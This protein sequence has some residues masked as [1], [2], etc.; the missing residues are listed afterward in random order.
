M[1]QAEYEL[2]FLAIKKVIGWVQLVKYFAVVAAGLFVCLY[3]CQIQELL[4]SQRKR[5]YLGPQNLV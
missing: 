1:S 4:Q 3:C 2:W 5:A